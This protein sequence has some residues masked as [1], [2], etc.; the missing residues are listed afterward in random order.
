MP[1]YPYSHPLRM[2]LQDLVCSSV[3]RHT[4]AADKAFVT[5]T[6]QRDLIAALTMDR[7]NE[8]CRGSP[9]TVSSATLLATT[10]FTQVRRA[11]VLCNPRSLFY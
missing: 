4:Q 1:Q 10:I 8:N 2:F 5:F 6:S 7:L 3:F 9:I 11:A